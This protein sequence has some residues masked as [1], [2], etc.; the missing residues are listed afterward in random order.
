M[1]HRISPNFFNQWLDNAMRDVFKASLKLGAQ[2][3]RTLCARR[4]FY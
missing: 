2:S 3:P 1:S 4:P